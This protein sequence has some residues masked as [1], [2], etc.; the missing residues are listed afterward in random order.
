MVMCCNC[1]FSRTPSEGVAMR[2][3]IH[4]AL[5]RVWFR[6]QTQFALRCVV[7]GLI[8]GSLGGLAV[9]LARLAFDVNVSWAVGAAVLAAGPVLG[10]L[11]GLSLRRGWHDAATAVDAHYG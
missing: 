5:Q 2:D 7:A 9:G 4:A 3:A 11:V 1:A 10:L 8:A 6:L